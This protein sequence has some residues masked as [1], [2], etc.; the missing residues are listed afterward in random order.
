MNDPTRMQGAEQAFYDEIIRLVTGKPQQLVWS[1][2]INLLV[3]AI[4]QCAAERKTAE[5]IFDE[6]TGRAK[7]VLLDMHYDSV[8]GKRR[9]VF[10]YTQV[11]QAPM[12]DE[13]SVVFHGQ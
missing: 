13:G 7:T 11:V 1:V 5:T 8:T 4:R 10:P 6:L 2:G 12:H 9:T 3:N